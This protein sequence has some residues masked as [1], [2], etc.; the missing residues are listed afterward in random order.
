MLHCFKKLYFASQV[1][2]TN[3]GNKAYL[4]ENK[5]TKIVLPGNNSTKGFPN[6]IKT[7]V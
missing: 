7:L 3:L 6:S 4:N 1:S 5:E 2:L